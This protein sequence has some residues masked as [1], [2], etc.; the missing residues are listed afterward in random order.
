[1]SIQ[2]EPHYSVVNGYA[3]PTIVAL[4][5]V[6]QGEFAFERNFIVSWTI[7][8]LILPVIKERWNKQSQQKLYEVVELSFMS[9]S[10]QTT[11]E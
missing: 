6:I 4:L 5:S 11:K 1:M 3:Y 9:S 7:N 10:I 2:I 8:G